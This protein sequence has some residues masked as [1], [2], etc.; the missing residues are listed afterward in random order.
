MFDISLVPPNNTV[1][2]AFLS[3]YVWD[4]FPQWDGDVDFWNVNS[5]TWSEGDSAQTMWNTPTLLSRPPSSTTR[6]PF[7]R[8]TRGWGDKGT[9]Q[10]INVSTYPSMTCRGG[11]SGPWWMRQSSQDCALSR[12]T[13]RDSL[14]ASISSSS[15]RDNCWSPEKRSCC[16]EHSPERFGRGSRET[17]SPLRYDKPLP[18]IDGEC[19]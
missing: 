8:E 17:G 15:P 9:H 7:D 3:V 19:L 10:L 4:V 13:R 6:S 1:D 14:Q 2:S 16:A 12:G 5:Q 11:W 18:H